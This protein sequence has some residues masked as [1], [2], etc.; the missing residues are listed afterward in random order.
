MIELWRYPVKSMGGESLLAA[1]VDELGI[2][3]DRGWGIVDLRSGTTL[4]ARRTPQLLFAGA[5]LVDGDLEIRLPDDTVVGDGDHA[6]LSAWLGRDV[7]LRAAGDTG[8]VF[9]AP[10]DPAT[11]LEWER[12]QGPPGAFHDSTRTRV[13][14]VSTGSLDTWD[15]RR[16]RPNVV[17][18]GDGEDELVGRSIRIGEVQ[19]DV[20]KRVDRCVMVTRPQPGL[21]R[22]LGVLTAINDERDRCLAI[23]CLV[24]EPGEM[25]LGNEVV[26]SG[27]A[28]QRAGT[29]AS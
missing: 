28:R 18:D 17:V 23:G 24:G 29:T 22:D 1:D 3:G 9:E 25:A 7:E 2:A 19:L 11:E 8:G 15:R 16:F 5:R 21:E 10:L 13:S 14:L 4:T 6:A 20:M 27:A 12:W 26:A